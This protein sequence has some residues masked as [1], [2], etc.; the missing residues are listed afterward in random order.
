MGSQRRT[1]ASGWKAGDPAE[2]DATL[3]EVLRQIDAEILEEP[4]PEKLRGILRRAQG[5]SEQDSP[6]DQD[7]RTRHR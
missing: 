2:S 6:D 1:P 5:G 3:D 7:H 4:V